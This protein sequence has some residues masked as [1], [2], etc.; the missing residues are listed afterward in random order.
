MMERWIVLAAE[1]A[2][3]ASNKMGG[4]WNVVDAE[5]VTLARLAA[6]G[7]IEE[8]PAYTG[9]RPQLSGLRIG[10]EHRQ[11]PGYRPQRLGGSAAG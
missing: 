8:R 9:G 10:L 6:R 11:E 4:I 5:A 2:G 1:E 3:P 7:R